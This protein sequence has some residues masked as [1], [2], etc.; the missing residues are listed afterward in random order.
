MKLVLDKK[1]KALSVY[2]VGDE[3]E[4][5]TGGNPGARE[6]LVHTFKNPRLLTDNAAIAKLPSVL[7]DAVV[8]TYE[9]P[10]RVTEYDGVSVFWSEAE[11]PGVWAPS[12]DTMLFARALR[13]ALAGTRRLKS[14][15]SLLEIGC[16]SG[17]LA[18]YVLAK[19]RVLGKPLEFAHLMDINRD[20]IKCALDN[21]DGVRR[22]TDVFYSHNRIGAPLRMDRR[23]D[24]VICNPPYIPRP[25]A[26]RGNPYEGLFLYHEIF[27]KAEAML[28]PDARLYICFSSLSEDAMLA[29]FKKKFRV[30]ILDS[31]KVPLKI[32]PVFSGLSAESC[33]WVKYLER[34]GTVMID[35]SERSGYR[36]WE[37]IRIAEC[38]LK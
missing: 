12:I 35:T 2:A 16:G 20:A 34:C 31:L 22:G 8:K 26:G 23:Y 21:L 5:V 30:R 15:R 9:F 27:D 13:K 18:K 37:T 6:F 10:E 17:F 24:L 3:V 38:A 4:K 29:L 14:A 25:A 36:Y 19:K 1:L 28:Q 32:P 33:R 11:Y 7:R